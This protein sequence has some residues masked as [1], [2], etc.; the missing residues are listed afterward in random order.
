MAQTEKKSSGAQTAIEWV[1]SLVFATALLILVFIFLFRAVTVSGTSMIPTLYGG[2]K[3][4]VQGVGYQP[5]RGDVIVVDGYI[6]YG[7]PIVKRIIGVGGDEV[8]I[9][10]ETATVTVNGEALNEPYLGTPTQR[11]GDVEFPLTVPEGMVFVL[12]DNRQASLD[13][14]YTDV[15]FIDSRDILGKVFF[16]VLPFSSIGA[17]R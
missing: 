16:R 14:R 13:S 12:G 3:I 17:I 11:R 7:E 9:N 4:I 10:F 6:N 8:D 1:E 2:D 15:G 5:C